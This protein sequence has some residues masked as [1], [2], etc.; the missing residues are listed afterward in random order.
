MLRAM[1][2]EGEPCPRVVQWI[3]DEWSKEMGIAGKRNFLGDKTLAGCEAY[4]C[5]N[6][7]LSTLC[8]AQKTEEIREHNKANGIK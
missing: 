7:V 2:I 5:K 6:P 4:G 3:H 1:K 8:I